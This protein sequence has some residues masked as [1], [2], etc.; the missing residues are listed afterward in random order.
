MR[1]FDKKAFFALWLILALFATF[2]CDGGEVYVPE[3]HEDSDSG[4]TN[5]DER[6]T[7]PGAVDSDSSDSSDSESSEDDDG[8]V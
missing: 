7:K 3:A 4:V 1:W 5:P 8:S 2:A 6:L